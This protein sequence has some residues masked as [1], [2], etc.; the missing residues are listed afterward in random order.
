VTYPPDNRKFSKTFKIRGIKSNEGA[1]FLAESFDKP[2]SSQDLFMLPAISDNG[3]A[4]FTW[5]NAKAG[6]PLAGYTNNDDPMIIIPANDLIPGADYHYELQVMDGVNNF[7]AYYNW[8]FMTNLIPSF[9][10]PPTTNCTTCYA[11]SDQFTLSAGTLTDDDDLAELVYTFFIKYTANTFYMVRSGPSSV[12]KNKLSKYA[13]FWKVRV[14][15]RT[16]DCVESADQAI[17][18]N[19]SP[20]RLLSSEILDD[21]NMQS[22][23]PENIPAATIVS[24]ITAT[25]DRET[26]NII[27]TTVD[28][29]VKS[30]EQTKYTRE[31][32][33]SV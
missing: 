30:L 15:D 19:T 32:V 26:Y 16:D 24:L 21:F 10:S 23:D 4:K 2:S 14:C 28:N 13:R 3:A 7:L 1:K 27:K 11:D 8:Y 12:Y 18:F 33:L 29:Y 25:L 9:I 22:E 31:L 6:T 17:T 20:G 5:N